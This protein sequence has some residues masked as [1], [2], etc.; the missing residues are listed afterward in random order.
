M[1]DFDSLYEKVKPELD[2]LNSDREILSGLKKK[3]LPY[4]FICL[5]VGV[6]LIA[7]I[8]VFALF[9]GAICCMVVYGIYYSK[10]KPLKAKIKTFYKSKVIPALINNLSKDLNYFPN[11]GFTEEEFKFSKIYTRDSDRYKTEDLIEGTIDKTSLKFAEVHSEYKSTDKDGNTSWHTIFRGIYYKSD[12]HKNFKGE[13]YILTDYSEK[14]IFKGIGKFFQ[15]KNFMR[16][17]LVQLEDPEFEKEFVVYSTDQIEARYILS[18]SVMSKLTEFKKQ[19]KD[20]QLSFI[21]N[22]M[23]LTISNKTDLFE[24]NYFS[25]EKDKKDLKL[26]YKYLSLVIGIVEELKLNDRLWSKE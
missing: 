9:V 15:R 5:G 22:Y 3:F 13:T 23:Y 26:Y 19:V 8:N 25:S 10:A 24:P 12:F 11:K 16:P 20:V 17:D 7:F 21:N 18:L 4:Y 2:Q 6:L 1:Q 14:T